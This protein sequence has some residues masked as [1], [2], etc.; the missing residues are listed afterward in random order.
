MRVEEAPLLHLPDADEHSWPEAFSPAPP[1]G[2]AIHVAPA[3]RCACVPASGNCRMPAASKLTRMTMRTHV[4]ATPPVPADTAIDARRGHCSHKNPR[5]MDPTWHLVGVCVEVGA[6]SP[7]RFDV[8]SACE[9][10]GSALHNAG[11][12]GTRLA[13]LL[14]AA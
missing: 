4:G 7:G 9:P 12:A 14:G 1:V 5:R 13:G 11:R 10:L 8:G 6:H 2:V 3:I